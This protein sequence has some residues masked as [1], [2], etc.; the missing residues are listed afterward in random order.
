MLDPTDFWKNNPCHGRRKGATRTG[1]STVPLL[2]QNTKQRSTDLRLYALLGDNSTY[3]NCVQMM[4]LTNFD[5]CAPNGPKIT[6]NTT[7][8]EPSQG[9]IF[10]S[11]P[12]LRPAV[13]KLKIPFRH[14]SID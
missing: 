7:R 5:A 4:H 6:L 11:V 12:I 8:S 9:P 2:M 14:K 1:M 3:D 10:Q 13:F